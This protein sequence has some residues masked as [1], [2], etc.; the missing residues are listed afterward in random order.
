MFELPPIAALNVTKDAIIKN[1]N[2]L[3]AMSYTDAEKITLAKE[4]LYASAAW[5]IG[6][7]LK[8]IISGPYET[9]VSFAEMMGDDTADA[10]KENFGQAAGSL[11]ELVAQKLLAYLPASGDEGK[12]L[13][14]FGVV[15]ADW[16]ALAGVEYTADHTVIPE[17]LRRAPLAAAGP[18]P[19]ATPLPI[20]SAPPAAPTQAE[21]IATI[22]LGPEGESHNDEDHGGTPHDNDEA[23]EEIGA[24]VDLP[25]AWKALLAGATLDMGDYAILLGVSRTS[26]S[27]WLNGKPPRKITPGQIRAM[28]RDCQARLQ[29]LTDA[30]IAFGG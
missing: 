5:L 18:A 30:L 23:D 16:Y 15:E 3:D 21:Q 7:A 10:V 4:H 20:P 29:H 26:A 25:K 2:Q 19:V 13:A 9:A 24:K 12:W 1:A 14:R 27:N 6:D 11:A 28:R 22:V 17:H 8:D